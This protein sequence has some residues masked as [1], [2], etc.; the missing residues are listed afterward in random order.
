[1]ELFGEEP[2]FHMQTHTF[3]ESLLALLVE[4]VWGSRI[5][6]YDGWCHH[7]VGVANEWSVSWASAT[8]IGPYNILD[9]GM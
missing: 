3:D 7:H 9:I 2:F 8:S 1:M 5:A 6:F 4:D